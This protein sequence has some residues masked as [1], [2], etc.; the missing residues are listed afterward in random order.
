MN[1]ADRA[2]RMAKGRQPAPRRRLPKLCVGMGHWTRS[3]S[4][5]AGWTSPEAGDAA[6]GV[7]YAAA[8]SA[9]A[10]EWANVA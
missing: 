4:D 8:I 7:A 2:A 9:T 1:E 3:S 6:V 5:C 10:A